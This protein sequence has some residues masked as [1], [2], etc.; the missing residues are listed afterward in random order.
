V[1]TTVLVQWAG[2][3]TNLDYTEAR[4]SDYQ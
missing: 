4:D 1:F 3:R 2:T